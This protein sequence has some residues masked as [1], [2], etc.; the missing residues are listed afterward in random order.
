MHKSLSQGHAICVF[1]PKEITSETEDLCEKPDEEMK[2]PTQELSG[3]S[4]AEPKSEVRKV[5]L[6]LVASMIEFS[7]IAP[8]F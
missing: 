2:E 8:P 3:K 1:S 6:L 4:P 5:D 7:K